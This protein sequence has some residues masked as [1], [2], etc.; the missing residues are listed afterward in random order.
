M[1]NKPKV[2]LVDDEPDILEVIGLY[3]ARQGFDVTTS[4][5]SQ[6]ALEIMAN[7]TFSIV[8]CDY[9]MPSMNGIE[10]LKKIREREDFTPFVFFSGNADEK[11]EHE[12]IGL[13][14][15][16]L[17][18]K[19]DFGK[20]KNVLQKVLKHHEYSKK[21]DESKTESTDAFIKLLHSG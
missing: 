8:I 2:L 14:A 1:N 17:L 11:N 4:Q 19:T 13:G 16:E 21:I 12:M 3:L 20:L 18:L 5:R 15:Y 6:D 10:F 7:N 9:L